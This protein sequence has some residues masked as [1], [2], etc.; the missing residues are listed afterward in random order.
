LC[1]ACC[2]YEWYP[3]FDAEYPVWASTVSASVG[4]G[5]DAPD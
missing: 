2:G 1:A 4:R 5:S 3:A